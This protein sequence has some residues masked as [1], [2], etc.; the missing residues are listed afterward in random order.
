M[1]PMTRSRPRPAGVPDRLTAEYYAQR[2]AW[3]DHHR[4]HPAVAD[5]AGL[6]DTPG[7][8]TAEQ[9]A[10]WR[11]SPT[12]CTPRAGA[13]FAQLMHTGRIGHPD[14]SPARHPPVAP[15]AVRRR[16]RS[17]PPTGP[18]ELRHPEASWTTDGDR[19][20]PSTTSPP[21]P[22]N[23][24]AAGFDGVELHG[25]NGYLIHQFLATNT[26]RAPTAGA[27]RSR[28]PRPVR[29]RGR[30]R[31]GRRDR[32]GADRAP[33]LARHPY[34]D[35]AETTCRRRTGALVERPG[36][37]GLALPASHG[38]PGPRPDQQPAQA[39]A[40]RA[41]P[42]PPHPADPPARRRWHDRGRYGGP[43]RLRRA[44][45]GQPGPARTRSPLAALQHPR[46]RH[47]LRRRSPRLHRLPRRSPA[48]EIT[49]PLSS[50]GTSTCRLF[51][52][53]H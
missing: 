4:G 46:P 40:E 41:H 52:R 51:H 13:I 34:N 24:M 15:S 32:R 38:G 11:R 17:S 36:P 49:R 45:P 1:A 39:V 5:R 8:H 26:N 48:T 3:A 6:P 43:D 47:L 23:A 50:K 44:V 16:A 21:P 29:R 35:I 2:A 31:G 37:L 28:G 9:I 18:Q 53:Q 7:L 30:D 33:H 19:R 10:G 27:A 12:R 42:Q 22:R 25:A 20:G 14:D